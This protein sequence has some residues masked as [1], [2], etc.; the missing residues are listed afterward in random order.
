[1]LVDKIKKYLF[2]ICIIVAFFSS[3]LF[4]PHIRELIIIW[5]ERIV[6]RTLTHEVWNKRLIKWECYFL[7]C[8]FV[9]IYLTLNITVKCYDFLSWT[10]IFFSSIILLT[11]GLQSGDIW[12]DE[13]FSLGLAR[14]R[15]TDLIKLTAQDVHP[16]LYYIILRSSMLIFPGSICAAKIISVIPII[17]I[18]TIV[19]VFFQREFSSKYGFLFNILLLSCYSVLTYAIE[20]RM[21]SWCL[22]FCC[23]C[24]IFSYYIIKKADWKSFFLYIFFAECGAYCQYWTAFGL[25]INFAL[26][27]IIS[28]KKNIKNLSK[29]LISTLLGI[30]LYLPWA[31]VVISQVKTVS[32]DYWIAPITLRDFMNWNLSLVPS[33]GILKIIILIIL[34]YLIFRVLHDVFNKNFRTQ[35]LIVTFVTPLLLI[36]CATLISL[37]MRPVFQE[38]YLFP[39]SIFLIFFFVI[40]I[41]DYKLKSKIISFLILLGIFYSVKENY[42][43]YK[44]EKK[45]AYKNIYFEKMMQEYATNNTVFIFSKD[46]DPHVAKCIAYRYPNTRIYNFDIS[47]MWASAIFYNIDNIVYNLKD[48]NNLCLVIPLDEEPYEDFAEI[49]PCIAKVDIHPESKF[50]FLNKK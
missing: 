7:F 26:I 8:I 33:S 12:Y 43:L 21:Y 36:I 45:L 30:I 1:M 37:I 11:I 29:S 31:K 49:E 23:L 48:E 19:N 20:I 5:G 3:F 4:I 24:C 17:A 25:A 35:F 47:E 32:Q 16:P 41:F 6:K 10:F 2:L 22:L 15:V 28:I 9:I 46:I 42:I 44:S 38:K 13:T 27:C 18:L 50:Y 14:H 39:L 40:S 34:F